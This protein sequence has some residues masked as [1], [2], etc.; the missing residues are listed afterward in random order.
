MSLRAKARDVLYTTFNVR[1]ALGFVWESSRGWT[2]ASA[3]L[4]MVQ[5]V[6]PV[7]SIYLLRLLVDAVVA[8]VSAAP[9]AAGAAAGGA[10]QRELY[11]V[12][13]AAGGVMLLAGITR[14]VG[15]LV[16]TEQSRRVVDHMHDVIQKKAIEVDLEF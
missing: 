8:A 13:F 11:V 16:N 14:I 1:R 10:P 3:L 15:T 12:L 5:G 2:I 7:V 4:L 9:P 6:L